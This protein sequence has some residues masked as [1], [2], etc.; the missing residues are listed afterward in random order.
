MAIW[1]LPSVPVL[2][3]DRHRQPGGQFAVHLAFGGAG[4]DG[5]PG[6]EVGGEL[7]GDG[8]EEFRPRRHAHVAEIEQQAPGPCAALG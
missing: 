7:R 3:A 5:T 2:E 1:M 6:N 8:I 4:A